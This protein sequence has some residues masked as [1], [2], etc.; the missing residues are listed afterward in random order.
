MNSQLNIRKIINRL[1]VKNVTFYSGLA[2]F[3]VFLIMRDTF[4]INMPRA[5][6]IALAVLVFIICDTSSIYCLI[7]FIAPMANGVS[8]TYILAIALIFILIKKGRPQLNVTAV[9][10]ICFILLMELLSSF[11]GEFSILEFLRFVGVFVT[12]FF[13]MT[14][15]DNKYNKTGIINC[16]LAGYIVAMIDLISQ[17]MAE[18]SLRELLTLGVRFGN[19]RETL[20]NDTDEMLLSYNPNGL[21]LLCLVTFFIALLMF[22]KKKNY[23]YILIALPAALLGITTQSITFIVVFAVSAVAYIVLSLRSKKDVVRTVLGFAIGAGVLLLI[24]FVF[25]PSS[26]QSFIERFKASDISNG[27]IEIMTYYF[28]QMFSHIDRLLIGV[29]MQDYQGKY[30]YEMSAH[31][32]TQ[33][34][35][36]MWGVFGLIAVVLLFMFIINNARR[37]NKNIKLIQYIPFFAILLAM[38]AGQ[39]FTDYVAVIWLMVAYSVL[40]LNM[41]VKKDVTEMPNAAVEV[42]SS[43]EPSEEQE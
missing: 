32:A 1:T 19:V 14:D 36:I 7:A 17:F 15:T 16:F 42:E 23:L 39:G 3:S 9:C 11:R 25:I 35:M 31:N 37:Q 26:I 5:A 2:L 18:Y 41:D 6:F 43:S 40:F 30:D 20:G 13:F 8:Y 27:R 21:G 29:G 12:I 22:R 28:G 4:N 24:A 10:L 33:E 38:Q 34:V